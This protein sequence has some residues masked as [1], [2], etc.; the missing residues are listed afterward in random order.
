MWNRLRF[1]FSHVSRNENHNKTIGGSR[2]AQTRLHLQDKQPVRPVPPDHDPS[3]EKHAEEEFKKMYPEADT[4][5]DV[6]AAQLKAKHLEKTQCV[7]IFEN[8]HTHTIRYF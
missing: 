6:H 1:D 2:K 4:E 7:C 5:M 8:T 3:L